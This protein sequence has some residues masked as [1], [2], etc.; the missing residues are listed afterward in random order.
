MDDFLQLASRM[1]ALYGGAGIPYLLLDGELQLAGGSD[2]P[3][4]VDWEA[5][6]ATLRAHLDGDGQKQWILPFHGGQDCMVQR[7]ETEEGGCYAVFPCAGGLPDP[8][9]FL[10]TM[11]HSFKSPLSILSGCLAQVDQA[12]LPGEQARDLECARDHCRQLDRLVTNALDAVR[13]RTN[14]ESY[15]FRCIDAAMQVDLLVQEY[16]L[17]VKRRPVSIRCLSDHSCLPVWAS[18]SLLDLAVANLIDN[19][20]KFCRTA[21]SVQVQSRDGQ[22]EILV[23]DDGDGLS[24]QV[25]PRLFE[26]NFTTRAPQ[27]GH[28]GSGLGL[29]LALDAARRMGGGIEAR[30][31]PGGGAQFVLRLPL[32]TT[33]SLSLHA[34]AEVGLRE[35][36]LSH[37]SLGPYFE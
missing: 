19:A 27:T 24:P 5:F 37:L 2:A 25:L 17:A 11:A 14:P 28:S 30:N 20:L 10:S 15:C 3:L 35:F 6:R 32:D 26:M 31:P 1:K 33:H 13:L 34:P 29:P 16:S 7:L 21:V 36:V 4:P 18:D 12:L 9:S 22:L 23:T 8:L